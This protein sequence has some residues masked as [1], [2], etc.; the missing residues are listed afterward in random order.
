MHAT[1][2][3]KTSAHVLNQKD[4]CHMHKVDGS[5]WKQHVKSG[6]IGASCQGSRA[7][8][9][10]GERLSGGYAAEEEGTRQH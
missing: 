6:S 8:L 4:S 3:G 10:T 5:S 1:E 2:Q 9:R 7:L